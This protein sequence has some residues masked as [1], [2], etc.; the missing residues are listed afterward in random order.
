MDT[1]CDKLIDVFIKP[2][3][4]CEK[5]G[6]EQA[7][8]RFIRAGS[9]LVCDACHKQYRESHVAYHNVPRDV[10][11]LQQELAGRVAHELHWICCITLQDLRENTWLLDRKRDSGHHIRTQQLVQELL[12]HG[13]TTVHV[14][15]ETTVHVSAEFMDTVKSAYLAKFDDWKEN[16]EDWR[17][18]GMWQRANELHSTVALALSRCRAL[19]SCGGTVD[20]EGDVQRLKAYNR[21]IYQLQEELDEPVTRGHMP[22]HLRAAITRR[23][24][25]TDTMLT[26]C[27]VA[28]GMA[29]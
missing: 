2:P 12:Q 13:R 6:N 16:N 15:T 1:T 8:S 9:Y 17:W 3:R 10:D 27:M 28:I 19:A 18:W 21:R 7:P 11:G 24:S 25:S 5:C 20:R 23:V 14:T 22:P 4:P 29:M 26:A